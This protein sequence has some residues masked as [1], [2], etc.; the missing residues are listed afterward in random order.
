MEAKL[1]KKIHINDKYDFYYNYE[2]RQLEIFSLTK[3]NK[4]DK[5]FFLN[6]KRR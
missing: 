2:A 4:L 5:K 1:F 3:E 6:A